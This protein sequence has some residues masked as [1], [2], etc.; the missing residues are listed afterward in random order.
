MKTGIDEDQDKETMDSS[1][2][3]EKQ[4]WKELSAYILQ[5]SELDKV[6]L[7]YFI[8]EFLHWI[9]ILYKETICQKQWQMKFNLSN[10]VLS[11]INTAKQVDGRHVWT[12]KSNLQHARQ[13]WLRVWDAELNFSAYCTLIAVIYNE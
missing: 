11:V 10:A 9:C 5:W 7:S 3:R 4:S 2:F 1:Q 6:I 13:V 8:F 12:W